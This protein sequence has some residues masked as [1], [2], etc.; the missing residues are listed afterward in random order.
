MIDLTGIDCSRFENGEDSVRQYA[1]VIPHE[2][3][4]GLAR[5]INQRILPGGF[6]R[7]VLS[8]DLMGA[9][10][11]A[12]PDSLAALQHICKFLY[13]HCPSPCHGSKE[14]MIAWIEGSE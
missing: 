13:N 6:L 3:L 10:C 11:R 8:N 1:P 9:V 12:D 14:K 5:Y 7:A 4:M 2:I